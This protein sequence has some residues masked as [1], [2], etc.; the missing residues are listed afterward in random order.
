MKVNLIYDCSYH[1]QRPH[2]SKTKTDEYCY[3]CVYIVKKD[4][5]PTV[6][7][8][9]TNDKGHFNI[10]KIIWGNG[11]GTGTFI[12]YKGEYGLTEFAYGITDTIENLEKIKA[13]MDNNRLKDFMEIFS[14]SRG[15]YNHKAIAL[16][17][18]D[19]WKEFL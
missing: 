1:I 8:S 6:W 4:G 14:D 10:P 16:F 12:D 5:T 9:N 7:Y 15:S 3:P 17:K 2:M 11:V 13:I 19:F 18:Q